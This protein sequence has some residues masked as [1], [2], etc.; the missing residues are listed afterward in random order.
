MQQS[1]KR[2][3]VLASVVHLGFALLVLL[4]T[5]WRPPERE[6]KP[7]VFELV[8]AP[9]S[10]A[11]A[12]PQ[13]EV[14]PV[15]FNIDLPPPPPPPVVRPRPP[16]PTP[17]PPPP[18]TPPRVE[19]P[20]PAPPPPP[21][22]KPEPR[23]TPPPPP[24]PPPQERVTIDQFRQTNPARPQPQPPRPTP[25]PTQ[26]VP[27]IDTTQITRELNAAITSSQQQAQV[28]QASSADQAALSSYFDRIKAAVR[29]AWAKPHGLHDQLKVEVRF[30]VSA[31]GVISNV[32]VARS[33]GNSIFDQSVLEAFSRVGSVG[34][35]PDR[36]PYSLRL[37]FRMTD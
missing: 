11:P 27:R 37:D 22:L 35:S 12:V 19:T 28:N 30:D 6:T 7:V 20:R 14:V 23:P 5:L 2:A 3:F 29:G 10:V 31:T 25:A 17:P 24:P 16:E 32:A 15:S 8:A 33:S 36:R 13:A 21:P 18:P 34:P 4:L 9:A 1:S 26:P